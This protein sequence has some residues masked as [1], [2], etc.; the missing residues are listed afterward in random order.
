MKKKLITSLVASTLTLGGIGF[1][2]TVF[3]MQP[4]IVH[5]Q[6]DINFDQGELSD[7]EYLNSI[8]DS[9]RSAEKLHSSQVDEVP[10]VDGSSLTQDTVVVHDGS[11]P[12]RQSTTTL[13]EEQTVLYYYNEGMLFDPISLHERLIPMM[14]TV[15]EEYESKIEE[16]KQQI[17][18]GVLVLN[19]QYAGEVL[20]PFEISFPEDQPFTSTENDD[21]VVRGFV[22]DYQLTESESELLGSL[23]PEGTTFNITF[24]VNPEDESLTLIQE[25]IFPEIEEDAEGISPFEEPLLTTTVYTLTD[26]VVQPLSDFETITYNEYLE[27]LSELE[28]DPVI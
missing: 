10:D 25:T 20:N 5:A 7:E 26:E 13:G 19:D 15:D 21:S 2:P 9:F 18:D 22:E 14:E 11:I 12:A 24:E 1:A 8:I 17:G 28:L 4:K 16:L 3:D 27:F 23:L 6:D